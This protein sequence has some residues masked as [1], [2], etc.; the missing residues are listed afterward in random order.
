MLEYEIWNFFVTIFENLKFIDSVIHHENFYFI[1]TKIF[2]SWRSTALFFHFYCLWA[3]YFLF[4]LMFF[5]LIFYILWTLFSYLKPKK[6][7]YENKNLFYIYLKIIPFVSSVTVFIWTF[8]SEKRNF[9]KDFLKIFVWNMILIIFSYFV[10][11]FLSFFYCEF[12]FDVNH[13]IC[14]F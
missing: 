8:L 14:H 7:I 9:K 13:S 6:L 3:L 1:H 4:W 11:L 5:D 2:F 12:W 10:F